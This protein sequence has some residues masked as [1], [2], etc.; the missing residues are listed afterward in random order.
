MRQLLL[1]IIASLLLGSLCAADIV[2]VVNPDSGVKSLSQDDAINIFMGRYKQLPS[3]ITALPVDLQQARAAFYQKLVGKTLAE[4]NSYW[5]RLVFSGQGSPPRQLT[6]AE[7]V[8]DAVSNNRGAIGYLD[9]QYVDD[10]VRVVLAF[11]P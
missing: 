6:S 8:I 5:A 2:V 9:R 1:A 4:I 10:R 7:E 11:T 3:G